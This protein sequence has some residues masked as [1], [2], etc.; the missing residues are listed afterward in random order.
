MALLK[1]VL[2][3]VI[4][5]TIIVVG[6]WLYATYTMTTTND[7]LWANVNANMPQPLREWACSEVRVRIKPEEVLAS[8]A[9][10]WAAAGAGEKVFDI[11][12]NPGPYGRV[13]RE[14]SG[15]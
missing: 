10:F 15:G 3:L 6:Y 9:D 1:T 8:C 12:D 2:G 14:P 4:L 7:K 13:V 5:A 11:P